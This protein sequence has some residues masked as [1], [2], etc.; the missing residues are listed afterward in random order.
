MA[1]PTINPDPTCVCLE[2]IHPDPDGLTI[3]LRT[4]RMSVPCPDCEQLSDDVHSWYQRTLTDLPWQGVA[5]RIQLHTRRW[6]C[7]NPACSRGIFTERLPDLV[8]VAA[9]RTNRLAEVVE[10]VAFALGGEAGARLL[11][12]IGLELSPDTLLNLIR[13]TAIPLAPSPRVIG[14]DDWAWRRGHR[15]GTILVDLERHQVIDLLPNRDP[16]TLI[17]WLQ[18]YPEIEVI[19]RDRWH[20]YREAATVGAPQARQVVD[21]WHLVDNLLEVVEEILL[22]K[23]AVLRAAAQAVNGAPAS[24]EAPGDST[25][26]PIM[27]HRPRRAAQRAEERSLQRQERIVARY[28]AIRR[29]HLAGADVADIARQVGVSRRTVY[30]YRELEEP[31]GRRQPTRRQT[32]LDPYI[33]YLLQRWNEG[34]HNGMQLWREIRAQGFPASATVVSRFV[35]QL[36]RD[37]AAGRPAGATAHSRRVRAPTARQ[38]A[39]L[40]VQRETDLTPD[41]QRYLYELRGLDTAVATTYTLTQTFLG[42]VR[43]RTGELL[44][45]WIAQAKESG[46]AKL[47]SFA[48]GLENDLAAVQV[49]LTEVWS[50]GQTEGQ[51]HRLKLVKRQMYGRAG[52]DVLRSR[53]IRAA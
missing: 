2:G 18:Q 4:S 44:E 47:R 39:R 31:P 22:G 50:N 26:G 53:V 27:P 28:E 6:F 29:L 23:R 43:E 42:M 51:I 38:M 13:S 15:Y 40:F 32:V 3:I 41:E 49:G 36:R 24:G 12:T 46:M 11:F 25:S 48:T 7:S 1:R 35:A 10:A 45:E 34:C 52:F 37:E 16:E 19:A 8:A 5:V 9:R 33:P 14:M 20:G 21:R 17:A 30:R